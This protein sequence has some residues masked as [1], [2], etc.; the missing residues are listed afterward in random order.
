MTLNNLKSVSQ[1][2]GHPSTKR[3][4]HLFPHVALSPRTPHGAEAAATHK[5]QNASAQP[6]APHDLRPINLRAALDAES[7]PP[8]NHDEDWWCAFSDWCT[9]AI[10]HEASDWCKLF[11]PNLRSQP[12]FFSS[13]VGSLDPVQKGC[14]SIILKL[15]ITRQFNSGW[16]GFSDN[17]A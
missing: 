14:E 10:V 9:S 1:N 16:D 3:F 7:F 6:C 15:I 4:K 12:K 8:W 13:W 2:L 11:M 5:P 17:W